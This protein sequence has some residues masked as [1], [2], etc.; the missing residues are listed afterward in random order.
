MKQHEQEYIKEFMGTGLMIFLT[1]LLIILA[2]PTVPFWIWNNKKFS[3]TIPF[4]WLVKF[5]EF[6]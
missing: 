6:Y 1:P 2:I 3:E 5:Y 4:K